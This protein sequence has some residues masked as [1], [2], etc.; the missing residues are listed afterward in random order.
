MRLDNWQSA[1]I[2]PDAWLQAISKSNPFS[3][4][5]A[6]GWSRKERLLRVG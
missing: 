5:G 2:S 3:A 1:H 4:K 6:C